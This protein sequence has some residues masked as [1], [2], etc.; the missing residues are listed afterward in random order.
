MHDCKKWTGLQ[1]SGV[2][3]GSFIAKSGYS[4]VHR[5]CY[6]TE[7]EVV[8]IS[9]NKRVVSQGRIQESEEGFF[10]TPISL[11]PHP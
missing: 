4:H 9:H 8:T 5:H 1:A 10:T 6:V 2:Y 11:K 3:K 7:Y